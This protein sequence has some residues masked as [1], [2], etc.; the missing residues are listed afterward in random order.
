MDNSLELT[1]WGVK[2]MKWGVRRY[3]NKDGS[4]TP[5]GR[6]RYSDDGDSSG[7]E[8]TDKKTGSG[9]KSTSEMS[10]DELMKAINRKR[11]ED[12][13]NALH[14]EQVSKGKKFM[15]GLVNKVIAP[16]AAESGKRFLTNY[17]NKMGDDLLK[18]QKTLTKAEKLKKEVDELRSEHDKLDLQKKID[19]L[20][21]G[22]K[23]DDDVN[24]DNLN[25]KWQYEQNKKKEAYDDLDRE[26]KTAKLQKEYDDWKNK[27][28]DKDS[29]TIVVDGKDLVKG[30]FTNSSTPPDSDSDI[31]KKGKS[32]IVEGLEILDLDDDDNW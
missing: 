22:K 6:K 32:I 8:S 18:E 29:D 20:K 4:L 12:Q 2:G 30:K 7:K 10:D 9:R 23:D 13:Y 27:N 31:V 17:M 11:L 16:A 15:D 21:S 25:K 26:Y 3:Q 1:H 19:K 28:S 5:A 14:P 24:Y